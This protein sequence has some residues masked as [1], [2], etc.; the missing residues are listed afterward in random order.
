VA[1][2]LGIS[3]KRAFGD[4]RL[5]LSGELDRSVLQGLEDAIADAER[6]ARRIE[7]D[8]GDLTFIDGGG[9]RVIQQAGLRAGRN[10]HELVVTNPTPWV[11]ELLEI[12]EL[13]RYIQIEGG[14]LAPR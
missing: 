10:G 1:A 14:E 3:V 5:A 12:C 6:R 11:R 13:D 7:L 2:L 8:L 4:V 9:L